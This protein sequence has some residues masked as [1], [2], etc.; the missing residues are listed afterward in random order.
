MLRLCSMEVAGFVG[1]GDG[2]EAGE[3]IEGR[4]SGSGD[5]FEGGDLFLESGGRVGGERLGAE[6]AEGEGVVMGLDWR[7]KRIKIVIGCIS[8]GRRGGGEANQ[9]LD[10]SRMRSLR[11]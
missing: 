4:W 3:G 6:G 8:E 10:S 7:G 5:G 1:F 9:K 2:E 11:H